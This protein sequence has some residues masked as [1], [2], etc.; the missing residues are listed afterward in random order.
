MYVC[1]CEDRI[2]RLLAFFLSLYSTNN[3]QC[4]FTIRSNVVVSVFFFRFSSLRCFVNVNR[5]VYIHKFD[6]EFNAKFL[7]RFPVCTAVSQCLSHY[8]CADCFIVLLVRVA[9]VRRAQYRETEIDVEEKKQIWKCMKLCH[10]ESALESPFR[11]FN[12]TKRRA[13]G[14]RERRDGISGEK[15][16]SQEWFDFAVNFM[17]V[18]RMAP[19]NFRILCA[20]SLARHR[21][22]VLIAHLCTHF[23]SYNS[24]NCCCC[25]CG[26]YTVICYCC[27]YC[28]CCFLFGLFTFRSSMIDNQPKLKCTRK[29]FAVFDVVVPFSIVEMEEAKAHSNNNNGNSTD[30]HTHTQSVVFSVVNNYYLYCCYFC[31]VVFFCSASSLSNVCFRF[32]D[33][34]A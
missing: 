4:Y 3:I 14:R 31:V 17:N 29:F 11:N 19:R 34:A 8:L 10:N 1:V 33:W 32:I 12:W 25:C 9:A 22:L 2:V 20:R 27:Y 18:E 15:T 26:W 28:C 16:T 5:F 23:Q 7:H 24:K 13:R 30:T 21:A 6:V